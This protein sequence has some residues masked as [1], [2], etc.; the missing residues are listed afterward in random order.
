M[1]FEEITSEFIKENQQLC[2]TMPKHGGPYPQQYKKTRRD[3][4][5]K[6]HFDY[7]YSARKIADMMKINRNTINS[8]I[9]YCYSQLQKQ[10]DGINSDDWL[11]KQFYRLESQRCRL[12]ERLDKTENLN[13]ILSLEKMIFEIDSKLA[14]INLKLQNTHQ[15]IYDETI[16]IFNQWLEKNGYNE[17]YVLWGSALKV[18]MD[19]SDKI[20]Q[21]INSDKYQKSP[22]KNVKHT[23]STSDAMSQ[24][25]F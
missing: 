12:T 10:D 14:Q 1:T 5:F 6:L 15:T 11:T 21:I 4:V 19:S 7:G 8:D 2:Q 24:R 25:K 23:S 22:K 16:N 9:T 13:D 18:T 17:R 3:E 20:K